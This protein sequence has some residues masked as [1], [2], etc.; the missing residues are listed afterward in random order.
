MSDKKRDRD[1][2]DKSD[3]VIPVVATVNSV[4]ALNGGGMRFT[5]EAVDT[6]PGTLTVFGVSDTGTQV[7]FTKRREM[8]RVFRS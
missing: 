8:F 1:D 3:V 7:S 5:V 2:D 4:V 6:P